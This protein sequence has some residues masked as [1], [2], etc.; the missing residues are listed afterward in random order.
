MLQYSFVKCL[1]TVRALPTKGLPLN[2]TSWLEIHRQN[3]CSTYKQP[4]HPKMYGLSDMNARPA[5]SLC[6]T[7]DPGNIAE[8]IPYW[9]RVNYTVIAY[10][11]PIQGASVQDEIPMIQR[12]CKCNTYCPEVNYSVLK[13]M[14]RG[15]LPMI[16]IQIQPRTR[17]A[18]LDPGLDPSSWPLTKP[19]TQTVS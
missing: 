19:L 6:F 11:L 8:C 2:H 12:E 7:C 10:V 3:T 9:C 17:P 1:W 14:F 16:S 4:Q 5:T 15:I 13:H 18:G